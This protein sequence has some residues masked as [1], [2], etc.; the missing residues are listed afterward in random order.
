MRIASASSRFLA[1]IAAAGALTLTLAAGSADAQVQQRPAGP[2]GSTVL[3]SHLPDLMPT[4]LGFATPPGFVKWGQTGVIDNPLH[5]DATRVGPQKNLCRVNV[6]YRTFN[7]GDGNATGFVTKTLVGG[8]LAHTHNVPGGLASKDFID[9]HQFDIDLAEGMNV[10]RVVYDANKQ[11]AET[12]ENNTFQVR[13]N[14]KV[15]CDGDGKVG[16]VASPVKGLK[17]APVKPDPDP[18]PTRTLRLKPA[19]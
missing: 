10:V 12:D 17:Q 6:A 16:G 5:V 1:T 15:D 3:T 18:A 13:I 8:T 2:A 14:V 4:S 9:W 7:K 11:V 19:N